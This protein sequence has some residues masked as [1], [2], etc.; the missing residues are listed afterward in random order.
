LQEKEF[1]SKIPLLPR[2]KAKGIE[3]SSK[4][5]PQERKRDR[6]SF[7]VSGKNALG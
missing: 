1:C 6:C 5:P 2:K 3:Y 4:I 7:Q